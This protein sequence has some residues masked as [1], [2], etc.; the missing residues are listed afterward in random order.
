MHDAGEDRM[1]VKGWIRRAYPCASAKQILLQWVISASSSWTICC[2]EALS[3]D[4]ANTA[5]L[6][7]AANRHCTGSGVIKT[8]KQ[9]TCGEQDGWDSTSA[10]TAS[11]TAATTWYLLPLN[12]TLALTFF[13][14]PFD[15]LLL[16]CCS[17]QSKYTWCDLLWSFPGT[18]ELSWAQLF[19]FVWK[20]IKP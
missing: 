5:G 11:E 18:Q 6:L 14:K 17:P 7:M 15:T 16:G 19:L 13:R 9:R 8:A 20:K 1:K 10:T 12:I 3:R 4:P 2:M